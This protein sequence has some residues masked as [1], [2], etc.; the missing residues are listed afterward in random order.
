MQKRDSA[1][2]HSPAIFSLLV[3]QLVFFGLRGIQE[4]RVTE[5]LPKVTHYRLL[6]FR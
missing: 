1:G 4:T 5:Y 3:Y 6:L 2:F